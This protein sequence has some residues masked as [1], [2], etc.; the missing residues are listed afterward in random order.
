[1]KKWIVFGMLAASAALVFLVPTAEAGGCKA[2]VVKKQKVVYHQQYAAAVVQEYV[3]PVVAQYVHIPVYGAY[4]T[5]PVKEQQTDG[6]LAKAVRE[7][8][9]EVRRLKSG[10]AAPPNGKPHDPFNPQPVKDPLSGWVGKHCAACHS[11]G[12]AKGGFAW[13]KDGK[14]VDLTPEQLGQVIAQVTAKTMP[15]PKSMQASMTD[16]ER[17]EGIQLLVAK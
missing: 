5:P 12:T 7:L 1:V 11:D 14:R 13:V 6:D 3:V 16:A 4:Y 9:D 2:V 8:A 15:P 10:Q 17:L